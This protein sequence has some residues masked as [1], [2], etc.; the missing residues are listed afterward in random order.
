MSDTL[1][2]EED[3][4][5]LNDFEEGYAKGLHDG[6]NDRM[7]VTNDMVD[8]AHKTM[9][10]E[11]FVLCQPDNGWVFGF[12]DDDKEFLRSALV[13]ALAPHTAR[14]AMEGDSA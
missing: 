8:R 1:K 10:S 11:L 14:D 13:A 2:I 9:M 5:R 7:V 6:L 3:A 12:L 4:Q